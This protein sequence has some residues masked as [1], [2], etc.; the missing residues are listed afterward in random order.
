MTGRSVAAGL[1]DYIGRGFPAPGPAPL[2]CFGRQVRICSPGATDGGKFVLGATNLFV[3]TNLFLLKRKGFLAENFRKKT[4]FLAKILQKKP[5]FWPKF[6][7]KNRLPG[8]P[9]LAFGR[10]INE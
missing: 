1:S 4:G 2:T 8:C 6:G 7:Q 9:R 5:A 10:G 3:G